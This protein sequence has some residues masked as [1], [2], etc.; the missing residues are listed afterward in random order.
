MNPDTLC[1]EKVWAYRDLQLLCMKLGI[2]GKGSR[3]SLEHKLISWHRARS[4]GRA[5][6]NRVNNSESGDSQDHAQ[7]ENMPMNVIGNNFSMLDMRGEVKSFR[8]ATAV[9]DSFNELEKSVNELRPSRGQWSSNRGILRRDDNSDFADVQKS[10]K[11][12]A[13]SKLTISPF[14]SVK[15]IP[16]RV[17]LKKVAHTLFE[18]EGGTDDS[19]TSEEYE[20]EYE[21]DAE[22]YEESELQEVDDNYY[23]DN[24]AIEQDGEEEIDAEGRQEG[25]EEEEE[26]DD[27]YLRITGQQEEPQDRSAS[28]PEGSD[29]MDIDSDAS[30]MDSGP[31]MVLSPAPVMRA[32]SQRLSEVVRRMF[33]E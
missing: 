14:N 6:L 25:E 1:N 21:E 4:K 5:I 20:L 22:Y 10:M 15:I 7:V 11:K 29:A 27:L 19:C 12:S 30:P 24:E 13:S 9:W 32:I 31:S 2:G 3:T 16:H 28:S 26:E 33:D 17:Q 23:N 18:E 8:A